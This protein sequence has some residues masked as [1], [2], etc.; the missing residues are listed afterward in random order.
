LLLARFLL[1][2]LVPRKAGRSPSGRLG[3]GFSTDGSGLFVAPVKVFIAVIVVD[4]IVTTF[5]LAGAVDLDIL[6][7]FGGGGSAF[8]TTQRLGRSIGCLQELF[9]LEGTRV[10]IFTVVVFF[11]V[12]GFDRPLLSL[13]VAIGVG[14]VLLLSERRATAAASGRNDSCRGFCFAFRGRGRSGI[15]G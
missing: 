1:R 11:F 10:F 15:E 14:D 9:L 13:V 8:G 3:L 5:L 6:L 4:A 12:L 7:L 2:S